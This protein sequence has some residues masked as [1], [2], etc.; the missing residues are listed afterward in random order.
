MQQL[1]EDEDSPARVPPVG[2]DQETEPPAP[3]QITRDMIVDLRKAAPEQLKVQTMMKLDTCGVNGDVSMEY[4]L[5][6]T[7]PEGTDELLP[8]QTL[9][10]L[11]Q[12]MTGMTTKSA[13]KLI[14]QAIV[15]DGIK[16]MN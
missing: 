3:K 2:S 16:K 13:K 10:E 11:G 9:Y 8:F 12:R 14:Y 15:E 4:G 7:T 5:G 6:L 1:S